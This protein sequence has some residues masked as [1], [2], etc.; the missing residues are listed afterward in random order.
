MPVRARLKFPDP[1]PW[2][3][4]SRLVNEGGFIIQARKRGEYL[5]VEKLAKPATPP[6]FEMLVNGELP[7]DVQLMLRRRCNGILM[8]FSDSTDVEL[9][10]RYDRVASTLPAHQAAFVRKWALENLDADEV[11]PLPESMMK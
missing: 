2:S 4:E 3:K 1:L 7:E 6:K 5:I 9:R 10:G 8:M 11:I